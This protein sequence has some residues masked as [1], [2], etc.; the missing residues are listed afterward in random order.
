[1]TDKTKQIRGKHFKTAFEAYA[2]IE[3]LCYRQGGLS[4]AQ[5]TID[6]EVVLVDKNEFRTTPKYAV[7]QRIWLEF[8]FWEWDTGLKSIT[9]THDIRFDC[10]ADTYEN[11]LITLA[12]KLFKVYG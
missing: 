4:N 3:E 6:V 8:G 2:Y 1:M 7:G 9:H 11:A 12:T 5:N 10:G